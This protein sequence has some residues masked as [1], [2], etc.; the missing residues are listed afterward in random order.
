[1]KVIGLLKSHYSIGK[2]I[3]T[4]EKTKGNLTDY[5]VS[6]FDLAIQNNQKNLVMVEDTLSGIIELSEN[7]KKNSL[8]LFF[9]LRI[10]ICQDIQQKDEASLKTEAKYIIFIK[11]ADGYKDLIKISSK[12]STDG[13]Y[14]IPRM[15][16]ATLKTLWNDKNLKLAVPFYDSF[17][18]LNTLESHSHVPDFSFAVPHFFIE[19]NDLPFDFIIKDKTENYCKLNS[20]ESYR[21]QSIYYA[22]EEDFTAFQ[23]FRCLSK[24]SDIE[25]PNLSHFSSHGFSFERWLKNEQI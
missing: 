14:Y 16:F 3:L 5:P 9:G 12:A 11:N 15:D 18:F 23:A 6:V 19:D 4:A 20:F 25:K 17:L 21:A 10:T 8:D 7:A 13:F 24:R 22:K 1:M 2:S